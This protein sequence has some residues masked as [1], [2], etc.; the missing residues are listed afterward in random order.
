MY[1]VL[2]DKENK[3]SA[4]QKLTLILWARKIDISQVAKNILQAG[5]VD[6]EGLIKPVER[7]DKSIGKYIKPILFRN[8][9]SWLWI[10]ER[11]Q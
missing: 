3:L 9:C 8:R 2:V 10:K 1:I 11:I 5:M 6:G 7:W 4:E